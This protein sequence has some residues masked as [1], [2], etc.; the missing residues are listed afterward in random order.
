[1]A[2]FTT[3]EATAVAAIQQLLG[4]W[5]YDL[6]FTECNDLSKV[7]TD[8]VVYVMGGKPYAGLPAIHAF[9]KGLFAGIKKGDTLPTRRHL[10]T[11][12]RTTFVSADEAAITFSLLWWTTD[13]PNHN[14]ADVAAVADVWMTCRRGK[15]GDWK[16]AK[17]DSVQP[18]KRFG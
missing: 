4:D 2:K 5:C 8:D 10:H 12:L 1:M 14:P 3:E 6:D 7:C 15:D 18:L 16:I 11:N 9:Y 13:F 17:F